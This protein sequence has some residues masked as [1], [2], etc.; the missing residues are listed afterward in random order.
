MANAI[1]IR[2]L[3]ETHHLRLGVISGASGLDREVSWTHVSEL[4]DPAP[5]LDGGELLMTNGLGIPAEAAAQ[6]ELVRRLDE[7]H[8]AGIAIGQ[9]APE[10]TQEMLTEANARKFALLDVP[11]EVPFLSIARMVADANQNSAQQRLL[12]HVRIF[13][14]LRPDGP[15]DGPQRIFSRLEEISGYSLYLISVVGAPLISGFRRPPA[16]VV[17]ALGG[18]DFEPKS[19]NPAV[20]GGFAVPVPLAQR[21]GTF[22]VALERPG[23]APAGLGAVR[24]MATIA[25]LELS[26]LYHERETVRRQGAEV[27]SKLFAGTLDLVVATDSLAALGLEP[28]EPLAVAALRADDGAWLND[29][30]VH[31]RLCDLEIP[32]L[33]LV[34]RDLFVILPA[35]AGGALDETIAELP[36]RAGVSRERVGLQSWSVAR[37][38]AVW[39]LERMGDGRDDAGRVRR[40][41]SADSS[42]HWLPADID[43]LQSLVDETLAPILDYD[44]ERNSTMLESLRVF[45]NHNRRLQTAAAE[46]HVHKHTLSYRLNR[47]EQITGRDLSSMADLVPLWLALQ[48]YEIVSE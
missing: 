47:I 19:A 43:T 41:S 46:L 25:A 31:H 40:F 9:R 20:P 15:A 2:D 45:F 11:L 5:W 18:E 42:V 22:L 3:L 17:E 39:A 30:E 24:H 1:T 33:M 13:D 38:E 36:L 35:A 7:R 32:H 23:V 10:L 14:T 21:P 27:L 12:T 34:D 8:V 29:D 16:D 44:T 26:K 37:K 48:A 6:V 4:E 28:A